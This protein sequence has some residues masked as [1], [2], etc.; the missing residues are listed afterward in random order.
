MRV[1]SPKTTIGMHI[2]VAMLVIVA[3]PGSSLGQLKSQVPQAPKVNQLEPLDAVKYLIQHGEYD[4]AQKEL[5]KIFRI[6]SN[7]PEALFLQAQLDGLRGDYN[8]AIKIYREMLVDN[9]GL[10]RVRLE[11]G[12]AL[13]L[14]HQYTESIYQFH[15]ALAGDVPPEVVSNVNVFLGNALRERNW[16]ASIGVAMIGSTNINQAPSTGTVNILG[17]PFQLSP[18][19]HTQAGIGIAPALSGEYDFP[20]DTNWKWRNL[21][22]FYTVQ[23]GGRDF[24]DLFYTLAS[25]PQVFLGRVDMSLLGVFFHRL[26]SNDPFETTYGPRLE[27]NWNI[28]E[29]WRLENEVEYAWRLWHPP[30]DYLNGWTADDTATTYYALSP[31]S[32]LR[33]ITGIG[34]EKSRDNEWSDMFHH[35]GLGYHREMS[36][37][38]TVEVQPEYY[39]FAYNGQQVLFGI[40]RADQIARLQTSVAKRDWAIDGFIP[41]ISYIYTQ[42]WSNVPIYSYVQ[43]QIQIGISRQF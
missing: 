8:G 19:A 5:N 13:Y 10:T 26:Y 29:R 36:F 38:L 22:S 41:S 25:G 31:T 33:L 9:P 34:W 43:H 18:Q 40:R 3:T 27:T 35:L 39:K 12:R 24:S 37:G 14:D 1:N 16:T 15:L 23:Y 2:L 30:N 6:A 32:F 20:L 42:D 21:G 28:G 4:E 17:L 7:N 11:L